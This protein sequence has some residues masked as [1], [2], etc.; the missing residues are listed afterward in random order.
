MDQGRDIRNG[1]MPLNLGRR[2]QRQLVMF[3]GR[4][5]VIG[6]EG[7]LVLRRRQESRDQPGKLP[8]P[9]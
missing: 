7:D 9:G 2:Y 1:E 5:I 3:A 4:S 8:F 6:L